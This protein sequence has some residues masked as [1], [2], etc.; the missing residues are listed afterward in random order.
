MNKLIYPGRLMFAIGITGLGI[1][2]IIMKDFIVGRPPA[3]SPT[4]NVNPT[5]AY[6]S[7]AI[8]LI[9]AIAIVLSLPKDAVPGRTAA[10][11]IVVLIVSLSLSRHLPRY[12]NDWV[13]VYKTLALIGGGLI[14]A[15]SFGGRSSKTLVLAGSLLVASFFIAGGYAHFKWADGVQ[16]LIPEYI[17]YRLF[18]TY[19]C[20]VCLFAG[21]IGIIIPAT[22]KWA[23][24]LSGIMISGWFLLLHIPRFLDDTSNASDRM[25]LCESFAVAGICFVL[26]GISRRER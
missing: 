18:W 14:V 16:Y 6:V 22:R 26:A 10:L 20:G 21:G 13:N 9:A 19:F 2:C 17:P 4:W 8:L 25:G 12:L 5:L 1:L 15:A 23:A 7:A 3:W 24:F 11:V